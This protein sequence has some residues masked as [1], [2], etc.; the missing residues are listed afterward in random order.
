M[1]SAAA[2]LVAWIGA[3]ARARST[4]PAL[5]E[6]ETT[7]TY[8]ELWDRSASVAREL[9]ADGLQP[10]N[11]VGIIGA[12]EAAY[13]INYLGIVRAG[14]TA[15]PVSNLLDG[16][17]VKD[18]M[19][20]AGVQSVF[21]GDVEADVREAVQGSFRVRPMRQAT[22]I[23]TTTRLPNVGPNSPCAVMLTSGSTG[24]PK[25][26]VHTQ[27]SMLHGA[28]QLVNTFPFSAN[29]RGLLFLPLYACIPEQVLPTLCSGGSL[30][31]L[32][33]F[34]IERVSDACARVTTFDAVPT[35]L[36]RLIEHV[37]PARL[38]HLKWV[39][40]ASEPMPIPLLE[41]WWTEVPNVELH[42]FYGMTEVLTLTAAPDSLLRLEPSTVGLP[43]ATTALTIDED[44]NRDDASGEICGLTP[45]RMKGYY[46]NPAATSAAIAGDGAMR[47]GDLGRLDDRGLLFLTG[48][49]K[50][51]IISGG[52]NVSPAEIEAV[53]C[54]HSAV[55]RAVVVG[56]PSPRWG[57]TPVVVAEARPGETL[58]P[59]DL[60]DHCRNQLT[61]YKRPSAVGIVTHLPTTG[62]GKTAKDVVRRQIL[63]GEINLVRIG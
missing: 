50:D 59:S 29:D 32:P 33:G 19:A 25:G 27:G 10:G 44:P 39:L 9:L 2:S 18:Q 21:L 22:F 47:T 17:S 20:F 53:A 5:V 14:G 46:E 15:V 61:G 43:F 11:A 38:A 54:R 31:I 40:F 7:I 23:G 55:Q 63:N 52:I 56:I 42:Q 41:R 57:E 28:L 48:R 16:Q 36:S 4:R 49:K 60:L 13:I 37:P 26:V 6:G 34:D 30:E 3:V 24:N 35:V 1:A 45:A 62:I 8:R 51:I 12:N 58:S